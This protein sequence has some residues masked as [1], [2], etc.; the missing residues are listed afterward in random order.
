MSFEKDDKLEGLVTIQN[1]D[2][3]IVDVWLELVIG[4]F[5]GG[6]YISPQVWL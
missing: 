2:S 6:K 1:S 5:V 3:H 4:E